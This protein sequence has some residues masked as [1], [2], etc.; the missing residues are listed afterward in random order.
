MTSQEKT[1]LLDLLSRVEEQLLRGW[2]KGCYARKANGTPI[3]P[4]NSQAALWCLLGA[5]DVVSSK[6]RQSVWV[7]SLYNLL[8]DVGPREGFVA[9][10]DLPTTT[11]EDVIALVRRARNYVLWKTVSEKISPQSQTDTLENVQL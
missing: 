10:N 2:T 9:Y 8:N 4:H 6:T 11:R 1:A 7:S 3:H 5:I